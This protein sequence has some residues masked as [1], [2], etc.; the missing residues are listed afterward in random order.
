[1][2][3]RW[4]D[5]REAEEKRVKKPRGEDPNQKRREDDESDAMEDLGLPG[6]PDEGPRP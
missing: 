3:G 6:D 1:M 2:S 4:K 5:E